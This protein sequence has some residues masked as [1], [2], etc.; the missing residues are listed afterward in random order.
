MTIQ[1]GR[2]LVGR[3]VLAPDLLAGKVCVV[4]GTG[5]GLGR[6]AA[7]ELARSGATVVG[8]GRRVEPIDDTAEMIR[9]EGG[10]ADAL[11]LDIRDAE[12]VKGFFDA[13]LERHGRVDVLLNNAG[14]QFL[15]PAEDITPKG[16]RTVIELNVLG[17]W[18]MTHAAAVKA[19]IPQG[20][21]RILSVTLSPHHGFPLMVHTGAARAAVESMTKT[22]SIEWA[23]YGITLCALAPGAMGTEVFNTKYPPD[24]RAIVEQGQPMARVGSEW[25]WANFVAYMASDAAGFFTGCVLTM[26]GGRDNYS[27]NFPPP[28]MHTING[29]PAE[30]RRVNPQSWKAGK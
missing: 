5:S 15:S 18:H 10:K 9:A 11:P 24:Y 30:T 17:T 6:A 3:R 16:Y 22:L 26:D 2:A 1:G 19:M 29:L 4:S 20:A 27:S 8:C 21:G 23:R 25:E 7:L 28:A 12:A 14:G 13:V